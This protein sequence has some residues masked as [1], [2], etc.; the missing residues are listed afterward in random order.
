MLKRICA[1]FLCITMLFAVSCS[2]NT[3]SADL[4]K[5]TKDGKTISSIDESFAYFLVSVY[6]SVYKSVAASR[7]DGWNSIVDEQNAVTLGDL[8]LEQVAQ[9]SKNL[10]MTEYLH[11]KEFSL[12]LTDDQKQSVKE[13]VESLH[14][15]YGGKEAFETQLSSFGATSKTIE[16]YFELMIKESNLTEYLYG[17]NGKR[18]ITEDAKKEYFETNYVIVDDILFSTQ[19]TTKDDGTVVSMPRD[20]VD[21]LHQKVLDIYESI[22]N[23]G[24]DYYEIKELYNED[25]DAAKY[26]PKG[27]FV[28]DDNTFPADFVDTAKRLDVEQV[29]FVKLASSGFHI[30][31]RLPMDASLYNAY[32]DVYMNIS[33]ALRKNDYASLCAQFEKNITVNEQGFK[34]FDVS[35]IAE[36]YA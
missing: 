26:Y 23:E 2:N 36:F 6:K 8:L 35:K 25:K 10:I 21:A 34:K 11:D 18:F 22:A 3:K 7:E 31:K 28:T 15:M 29:G 32:E 33:N 16:K 5:F 14:S 1:L 17:E 13:Q 9:T 4:V 12:S 24:K 20:E 30:L 27:F 19:G